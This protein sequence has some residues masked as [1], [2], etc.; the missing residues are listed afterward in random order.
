VIA[1]A[2]SAHSGPYAPLSVRVPGIPRTTPG[3]FW[4]CPECEPTCRPAALGGGGL[5]PTPL[6]L[7]DCGA[8]ENRTP[9]HQA[10]NARATT[11]P[12]SLPDA[13]R[14]A[15]RLAVDHSAAHESSFRIVIGL[16]RRQQSFQ[17]SSPASVAGLRWIG[18]VR[19]RWSR[20][21]YC[22]LKI[23]RRRRTA[24]WQFL[25]LPRLASLSN[26]GRTPAQEL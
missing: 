8:G 1:R 26:S 22:L 9:V 20:C 11:I 12:D 19:H 14:P 5:S 15:G 21:T 7:F 2:Q 16:S 23:R 17:L 25:W 18:P 4:A 13:G 3:S 24:R 6:C 10:L